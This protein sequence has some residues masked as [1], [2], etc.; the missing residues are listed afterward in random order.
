MS[1]RKG[2][3]NKKKSLNFLNILGILWNMFMY[4]KLNGEIT[5]IADVVPH[6]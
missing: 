1:N 3:L 2:K 6:H 4:R 5:V